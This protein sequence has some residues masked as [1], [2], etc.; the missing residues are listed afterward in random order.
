MAAGRGDDSHM[1]PVI[2]LL[3]MLFT[4]TSFATAETLPAEVPYLH[5]VPQNLVPTPGPPLAL[6]LH[7]GY[8]D[9]ENVSEQLTG[10][11]GNS[12]L[13]VGVYLYPKERIAYLLEIFNLN[14][15]FDMPASTSQRTNSGGLPM[16]T[17]AVLLG[18]RVAFPV[19]QPLRL[20]ASG[21][22]GYFYSRL[23]EAAKTRTFYFG[24]PIEIDDSDSALGLHAGMGIDAI[25]NGWV[26]G[27][28][29]RH[30]FVNGSFDA[31]GIGDVNLGGS[32]YSFS[33]GKI[34]F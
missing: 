29:F 31:S 1:K 18:A 12:A 19:D 5:D 7:L 10:E 13:G 8:F 24:P 23:G 17:I 14:R 33:I 9:G 34:F 20:H 16:N 22:G 6:R 15:D 2:L 28:E 32:L 3:V 26:F 25:V 11:S 4:A 21:G 30:W 27:V